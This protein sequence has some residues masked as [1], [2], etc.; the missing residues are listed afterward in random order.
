MAQG[1]AARQ[2]S[3]SGELI[4]ALTLATFQDLITLALKNAGVIGVGQTA[5]AEDMNDACQMLNAMISQWQRRRY[6][7]YHLKDMSVT[8]T[9]AE[10]YS[11]GQNG[12]FDISSR[13]ASIKGAY[14]RQVINANPN[15]IDYQIR[16]LPSRETYAQIAMKS[17]Q[18]FPQWAW[19]DAAYPLG[20][21]FVYPVI[22]SQFEIHILVEEILQTVE[23]LTDAMNI[24]PEY[25][26]AMLY[27][28]AI[29]LSAAWASPLNP[30]VVGLAKASL[31]TL[32]TANAQVPIMQMPR[33]LVSAARYNIFSDSAN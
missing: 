30:A 1:Q 28:L 9:G 16:I 23:N 20:S 17:L 8:A 13:P 4:M 29:R 32:R 2:S 7:V 5:S 24:P 31:E 18:S 12:D 26:E 19:Y 6:L 27:N 15:Q 33:G 22:S 14:A 25:T 11:V 21:L 3:A 10:S